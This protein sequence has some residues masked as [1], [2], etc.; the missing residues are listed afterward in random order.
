[1]VVGGLGVGSSL[2]QPSVRAARSVERES[3]RSRAAAS[4]SMVLSTTIV[5]VVLGPV[6]ALRGGWW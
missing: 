1:M 5:V 4:R 3:P 2:N 6:E